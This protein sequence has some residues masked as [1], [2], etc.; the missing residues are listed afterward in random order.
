MKFLARPTYRGG[1][2][3]TDEEIS[4]LYYTRSEVDLQLADYSLLTHDHDDRYYTE[5]EITTLLAGYSSTSHD[6]DLVYSPLTHDH[7]DRYYTETEADARFGRLA[8][9]NAWTEQNTFAGKVGIGTTAPLSELHVKSSG[10]GAKIVIQS[11]VADVTYA[12][13]A[14]YFKTLTGT[15][16]NFKKNAIISE[17]LGTYGYARGNLHLAVRTSSDATD[18]AVSDSKLMIDGATGYVGIGTTSPDG[19]L[20]VEW[21]GAG[22]AAQF[23]TT[24]G[25]A[26]VI[27]AGDH[28]TDY[29]P[30]LTFRRARGLITSP[31]A[32]QSGDGILSLQAGGYDGSSW[33]S[34]WNGGVRVRGN[35]SENWSSTARGAYLAFSTTPN[36]T[37]SD[38]TRLFV[39]NN[40]YIGIGTMSPTGRLHVSS[41]ESS[42]TN[43]L[44][45]TDNA[46]RD[47]GIKLA[48]IDSLPVIQTYSVS[49]GT[50]T[51]NLSLQPNAGNVGI[52][53]TSISYKLH[54]VGTSMFNGDAII[55]D[56]V[57]Y[58]GARLNVVDNAEGV[59]A[60]IGSRVS[61]RTQGLYIETDQD[62]PYTTTLYSS[63]TSGAP[64]A[65]ATGG[66]GTS[67]KMTLLADGKFGIGTASPQ[68][69]VH[70][71]DGTGGM[72]FVSKT[73]I[74]STPVTLI[75]NGTGDV[76]SLY[77]T[78]L[79]HVKSS[80]G[81]AKTA[82]LAVDS[83][84][85]QIV[86]T[87]GTSDGV[88]FTVNADGSL[89]VTRIGST[90]P[91]YSVV[92]FILWQ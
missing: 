78:G 28:A 90:S 68:G 80:T 59:N 9:A 17:R 35:A 76:A 63:G 3:S 75:A 36:G 46:Y 66:I 30:L 83:S 79:V 23:A 19:Q 41:S 50:D 57:A 60:F 8:S 81:A 10:D 65:F 47:V 58:G 4:L 67:T 25:G 92:G 15:T 54:L 42:S 49:A 87:V 5:G 31:T 39:G 56:V 84:G 16:D 64:L 69:L 13:A 7:D 48:T 52:G 45:R 37:T 32:V 53:A 22:W 55:G 70:A 89:T 38:V 1:D 18:A 6:H 51:G 44:L 2:I 71:H 85:N 14:L 29:T 74:G 43:V 27:V 77:A 88:Y 24:G 40:G 91:T 21:G 12:T 62:S 26:R 73:G 33:T 72:L 86:F 61:G 11:N 20:D 34:G 82:V